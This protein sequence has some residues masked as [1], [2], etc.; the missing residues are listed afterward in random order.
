MIKTII[1]EDDPM[2]AQ[3]N[4]RYLDTANDIQVAAVFDNGKD[5]LAYI[6]NEEPDLIILDVYMPVMNGLE[7]LREIRKSDIQ[8]DVIM[9]TAANDVKNVEEALRLGIVDYLV[10]PFEYERFMEAIEK[11][12][13]KAH[14]LKD[15]S[16]LN[17]DAIDAL[18]SVGAPQQQAPVR[19]L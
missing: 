4:R 17:Q 1:V 12:R 2:V 8:S 7:L 16:T 19:D 11:Y 10:K 15:A 14:V 6:E 13:K 18:V 5:A 3:I 9:V